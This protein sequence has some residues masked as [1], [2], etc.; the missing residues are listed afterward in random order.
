G[1]AE[2]D[3]AADRRGSSL[4]RNPRGSRPGNLRGRVPPRWPGYGARRDLARSDL[5]ALGDLHAQGE[6]LLRGN[7]R[8]AEAAAAGQLLVEAAERAHSLVAV[9]LGDP[10][11]PEGVVS[12]HGASDGE[13]PRRPGG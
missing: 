2:V 3:S 6:P 8:G 5:H 1:S 7:H 10:T 12:P 13:V 9:R 4:G 11:E